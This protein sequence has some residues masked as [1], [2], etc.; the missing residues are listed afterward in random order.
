MGEQTLR[1]GGQTFVEGGGAD[2]EAVGHDAH[3]VPLGGQVENEVACAASGAGHCAA[4]IAQLGAIGH[5]VDAVG[6]CHAASVEVVVVDADGQHVAVDGGLAELDALERAGGEL[7]VLEV[8]AQR[9]GVFATGAADVVL[10]EQPVLGGAQVVSLAA[11][12]FVDGLVEVAAH[13]GDDCEAGAMQRLSLAVRV[14]GGG[15]GALHV[16]ALPVEADHVAE[17]PDES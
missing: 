1:A 15:E 5:E 4:G 14:G 10:H 6:G 9:V 12:A 16:L 3:A 11:E 8:E 2:G 7:E 17:L 13:A